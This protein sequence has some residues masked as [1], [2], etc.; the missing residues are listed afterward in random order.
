MYKHLQY[1]SA[2][3]F[4][5]DTDNLYLRIDF[6]SSP[7][8]MAANV[9]IVKPRAINV[10]APIGG[11]RMTLFS[12]EAEAPLPM[13]DLSGVAFKNILEMK[14]PFSDIS[15]VPGKRLRFYMSL[16]KDDL[17]VER[18]PGSGLLSLTIP[19]KSYERVMWH[20]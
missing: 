12:T 13:S 16:M 9:H 19:D 10:R 7:A 17:E 6:A 20:V 15:A 8:G 11:S 3:F 14:I 4:G 18:H 5:F 2:V 1:I